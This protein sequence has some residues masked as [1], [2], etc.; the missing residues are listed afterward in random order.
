M[1]FIAKHETLVKIAYYIQK[2][3]TGSRRKFAK[4]MDIEEDRLKDCIAI[5]RIFAENEDA[6]IHY[7]QQKETYYFSPQGK[8][9]E[10]KFRMCFDNQIDTLPQEVP[11]KDIKF[12]K[13]LNLLTK[14][15][16]FIHLRQTGTRKDFAEKLG[17]KEETIKKY[18]ITLKELADEK[19]AKIR[20]DKQNKTYYFDQKGYFI[21]HPA[22]CR[23]ILQ[24]CHRIQT[25]QAQSAHGC[26]LVFPSAN[27]AFD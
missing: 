2:E 1:N 17:F 8:F 10:F 26:T 21:Y 3:N 13:E 11:H 16:Y 15:A 25:A 22:N 5:L 14:M 7:D 27:Q 19:D 6:K 9:T 18:I 20:F 4:E 23:R 24:G 12:I